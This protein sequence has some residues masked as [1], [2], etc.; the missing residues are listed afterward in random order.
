MK[1]SFVIKFNNMIAM[2]PFIELSDYCLI[3]SSK[4][5]LDKNAMAQSTYLN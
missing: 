3:L 5:I 2:P 4:L 1:N